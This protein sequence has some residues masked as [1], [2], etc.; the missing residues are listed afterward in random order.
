MK[1]RSCCH[2]PDD[3][4]RLTMYESVDSEDLE[5]NHRGSQYVELAE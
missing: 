5:K 4:A 3:K 1:F 2:N